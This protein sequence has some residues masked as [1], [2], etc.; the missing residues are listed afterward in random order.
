[1]EM[2]SILAE[3]ELLAEFYNNISPAA[4][5][6]YILGELILLFPE[7]V[8]EWGRPLMFFPCSR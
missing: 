8:K 1:M 6:K 2:N 4:N 5:R 3:R 7:K